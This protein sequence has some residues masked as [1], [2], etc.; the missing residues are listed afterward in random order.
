MRN[1]IFIS[2]SLLAT[3]LLVSPTRA[4]QDQ[5]AQAQ[6]LLAQADQQAQ[7]AQVDIQFDQQPSL[8]ASNETIEKI[9]KQLDETNRQL[10]QQSN[11]PALRDK[12]A[13]LKAEL[14]DA[15]NRVSERAAHIA[16]ERARSYKLYLNDSNVPFKYRGVQGWWNAVDQYSRLTSD[17]TSMAVAAVLQASDILKP[18]GA[19]AQID[20]FEALLPQAKNETVKRA[21]RL[22][23]IDAYKQA[24]NQDKALDE[25]Q[26]L[27]T[28]APKAK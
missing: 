12:M 22:Q 16:E 5:V 1:A 19:Q 15:S 27:I 21:I 18:R 13:K 28:A 17:S 11:N 23:L 6:L 9:R 4:Q 10:E 8:D 26:T 20:Y 3:V 2:T 7:Q 25:L 14:A 24:N